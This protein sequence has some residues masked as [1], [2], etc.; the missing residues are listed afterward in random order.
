MAFSEVEECVKA[1]QAKDAKEAEKQKERQ[2]AINQKL[3]K[4]YEEEFE[5]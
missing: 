2:N 1:K 3:K 4:Q 5:R